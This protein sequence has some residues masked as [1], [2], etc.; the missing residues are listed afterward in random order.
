MMMAPTPTRAM[1]TM[2]GDELNT[3][4]QEGLKLKTKGPGRHAKTY[5]GRTAADGPKPDDC[6]EL[7]ARFHELEAIKGAIKLMEA[8][9]EASKDATSGQKASTGHFMKPYLTKRDNCEKGINAWMAKKTADAEMSAELALRKAELMV[10]FKAAEQ[11]KKAAAKHEASRG[12]AARGQAR[13]RGRARRRRPSAPTPPRRWPSHGRGRS[14]SGRGRGRD[15]RHRHHGGE[16]GH[17]HLRPLHQDE[18]ARRRLRASRVGSLGGA[19]EGET[20]RLRD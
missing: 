6:L 1:T 3:A 12:A 10:G 7:K 4:P 15:L 8:D 11:A 14:S 18:R 19:E 20:E 17:P 2:L 13:S 5:E 16:C 9:F